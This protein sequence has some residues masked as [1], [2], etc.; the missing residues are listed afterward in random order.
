M[1]MHPEDFA[2][3]P[4]NL[5]KLSQLK[6]GDTFEH[7]YRLRNIQGEWQNFFVREIIFARTSDGKIKQILG[8]ATDLTQIKQAEEE[9]R[10]LAVIQ[11][12]ALEGISQLDIHGS[13]INVNQAYAHTMGYEP[14]QMIGL[15]WVQTVHPDDRNRLAQLYQEMLVVRKVEA[16]ARGIR[17]DGSVF[18]KHVVMI[19]NYDRKGHF[20]GHYCFMKD[21]SQRQYAERKLR[22]QSAAM[23]AASDGIGILNQDGEFVYVNEAYLKMFGYEDP[24]KLLGKSWEDLYSVSEL[25]R[26]QLEVMCNLL[27]EGHCRLEMMGCRQ[28][29]SEFLQEVSVTLLESGERVC[30]VRDCTARKQSEAALKA[31]EERLQLAIEGSDLGLW[32]WQ[33]QTGEAY[34]SRQWKA[35]LG[36]DEA[37]IENSYESWLQLVHPEDIPQAVETLTACLEDRAST[38]E[39][40]LRMLSKSGDWQWILVQGKIVERDSQGKPIRMAGTH[41]NISERKQAEI[42]KEHQLKRERLVNAILE[43]IHSSLNLNEVLN[44]ASTEVRQ[45]LETDRVLIYQIDSNGVRRGV[46][47][48][49]APGW[50]AILGQSFSQDYLPPEYHELKRSGGVIKIEDTE[51]ANVSLELRTF[52]DLAGIKAKVVLPIMQEETLW[53]LLAVHYCQGVRHWLHSEIESLKQIAVQLG[54]AVQQSTLFQQAKAELAERQKAEEALQINQRL[55]Q[56]ITDTS[57]NLLYIYDLKEQI[58]VYSNPQMSEFLGYSAREIYEMGS[59]LLPT[60]IHPD[61][62]PEVVEQAQKFHR[63]EVQDGEIVESEYRLRNYRGEWCDV[64]SRVGVFS[65]TSEGDVKQIIG[66]ATDIRELKETEAALRE[67]SQREQALTLAIQRIRQSLDLET[68]FAATTEEVRQ[69][70]NCERVTI[71]QFDQNYSGA[72]VAESVGKPEFSLVQRLPPLELNMNAQGMEECAVQSLFNA[73]STWEDSYLMQNWP[74]DLF[75]TDITCSMVADIYEQNFSSCYVERLE[76]FHIRA[77]IIAPIYCGSR[78]WGLLATYQCSTPRSWKISDRNTVIQISN[79]L[80]VALQQFEL[81]EQTKHQSKALEQAA[82]VAEAAN[83]AKSEFLA[84]MSHELRTP[85]NAILGFTQVMSGDGSLGQDHQQRLGIINR[86]GSHLLNLIND[87]LEMSKIEAGRTILNETEF[88]PI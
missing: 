60:I 43:R 78:L 10:N 74:G 28:D 80:G 44:T 30:I 87:T 65:R 9:L 14:Q 58:N 86:A 3:I 63:G 31:S 45:F 57:P 26:F 47:E 38:Y 27:E 29:G 61:D 68:I 81:L 51:K 37:E 52:I 85:L 7:N 24:S 56:K 54:I 77:Y 53:G 75:K 20:I 32:D 67:S 1:I 83:R 22:Q 41:Q 23:A 2:Q 49:V 73:P 42:A 8:T 62:F 11:Q 34:L 48:S 12:N 72:F 25:E 50:F 4:A 5:E 76:Q 16:D 13:Y 21:I 66:T 64:L 70:I 55:L 33:L 19:A 69:V 39:V 40:E 35:M 88:V 15:N 6:D 36:Y 79:Q 59:N 84:N 17:K 18:D 46:T 82:I 71:Y